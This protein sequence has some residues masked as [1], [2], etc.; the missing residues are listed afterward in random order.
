[1]EKE[2]RELICSVFPSFE[3]QR[4]EP[5]N[6]F[7]VA[8]EDKQRTWLFACKNLTGREER[9]M[10]PGLYPFEKAR[11]GLI[12]ETVECFEKQRGEPCIFSIRLR[13]STGE[14]KTKTQRIPKGE[15][16]DLDS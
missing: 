15:G 9:A 13:R 11:T 16:G 10:G 7:F 8:F 12:S 2:R 14:H 6:I 5:S 4:S 1:L 3:K